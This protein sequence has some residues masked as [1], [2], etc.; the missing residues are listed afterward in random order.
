VF[1]GTAA[2]STTQLSGST[3]GR[4]WRGSEPYPLSQ[5]MA[6]HYIWYSVGTRPL[7]EK[8]RGGVSSLVTGTPLPATPNQKRIVLDW[9]VRPALPRRA[10]TPPGQAPIAPRSRRVGIAR[11]SLGI[12]WHFSRCLL[13]VGMNASNKRN[14]RRGVRPTRD[15]LLISAPACP[16]PT[17]VQYI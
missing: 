14:M 16:T 1:E 12:T 5:A 15:L 2:F 17:S 8:N 11:E 10:E 7:S 4:G 6:G 13:L 3:T 9:K